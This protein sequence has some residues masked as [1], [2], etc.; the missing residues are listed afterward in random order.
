[1]IKLNKPSELEHPTISDIGKSLINY[2]KGQKTMTTFT[3]LYTGCMGAGKTQ[4]L[5]DHYHQ[6]TKYNIDVTIM[7][8]NGDNVVSRTGDTL[9]SIKATDEN[10]KNCKSQLILVDEYQFLNAFMFM[11]LIQ[12]EHAEVRMY[13]LKNWANPESV[14]GNY[15]YA[16]K[17]CVQLHH[18]DM[19]CQLTNCTNQAECNA[20][21]TPDMLY[22]DL[23]AIDEN[24]QVN[25]A[26]N[27][28]QIPKS[29]FMAMCGAC[30][31]KTK[32]KGDKK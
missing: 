7:I 4:L 11:N 25:T 8:P 3:R 16:D 20:L 21:M 31:H 28:T 14:C 17:F 6:H 19:E 12:H 24:G 27:P 1:M 9:P 29:R 5:I 15:S 30:Y 22:L 13:G 26:L 23:D 18:I 2:M 10:L 32:E